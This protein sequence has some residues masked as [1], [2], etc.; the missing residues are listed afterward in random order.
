VHAKISRPAVSA[1]PAVRW[2]LERLPPRGDRLRGLRVFAVLQDG[3]TIFTGQTYSFG[4]IESDAAGDVLAGT[5]TIEVAYEGS[6]SAGIASEGS[7]CIPTCSYF[8]QASSP[9]DGQIVLTAGAATTTTS[10][11]AVLP[12][13]I[14]S[15]SVGQASFALDTGTIGSTTY[16]LLA[17][18]VAVHGFGAQCVSADTSVATVAIDD[19]SVQP[20]G[21]STGVFVVTG[22]AAGTT[23]ITCGMSGVQQ[24]LAVTVK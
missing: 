17:G 14:D 1:V 5:G 7:R 22:V 8:I 23:T 16:S 4:V 11:H 21:Q 20:L 15:I 3:A 10:I 6:L 2:A 13:S 12:S 19:S 18:G 9:G 24:A